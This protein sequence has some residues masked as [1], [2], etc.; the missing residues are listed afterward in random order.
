MWEP[1]VGELCVCVY[2]GNFHYGGVGAKKYLREKEIYRVSGVKPGTSCLTGET[3]LF[4][5][6]EESPGNFF[7]SQRFR[8]VSHVRT[9]EFRK[10]VS[11]IPSKKETA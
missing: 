3:R 1:K 4:I 11:P 10:L 6:V 7:D 2:L 5:S 8:P 9:E